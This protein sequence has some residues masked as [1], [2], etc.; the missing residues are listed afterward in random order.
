MSLSNII[1]TNG[2]TIESGVTIGSVNAV[3]FTVTSADIS[4]PVIWGSQYSA[5]SSSG[6]TS[7]PSGYVYQ[8]IQYTIT[9]GLES[10]ITSAFN[11]GGL[12]L[13][14]GYAFQVSWQSG[15]TGIIRVALDGLAPTSLLLSP[16]DTTDTQWQTGSINGPKQAGTFAFPATFTLYQPTTSMQSNISWC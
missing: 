7:D 13:G 5:Y 12:N 9:S 14:Y 6:F 2:V 8:L 3:S 10:A 1:I 15:G 16:I 11:G 4:S